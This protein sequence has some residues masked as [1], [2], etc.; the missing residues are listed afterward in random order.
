MSVLS[1]TSI[2]SY[3]RISIIPPQIYTHI[4]VNRLVDNICYL[5]EKTDLVTII[6]LR[7][8]DILPKGKSSSDSNLIFMKSFLYSIVSLLFIVSI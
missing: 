5:L 2:L 7:I 3:C 1:E 8:L 6:M 4:H